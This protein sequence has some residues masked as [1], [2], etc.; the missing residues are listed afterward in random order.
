MAEVTE[1]T[2]PRVIVLAAGEGF[3]LD[4]FNK[5]LIKHPV[6]GEPII[7]HYQRLFHGYEMTVV[8]GFRALAVMHEYPALKYI[9]CADWR[10]NKNAYSLAL[11]LDERPSIVLSSDFFLSHRLVEAIKSGPPD[12]VLAMHRENRSEGALNLSVDGGLVTGVYQGSPRSALDPEAPGVFKASSPA[13]LRQWR[14]RCYEHP[15]RFCLETLPLQ[16]KQAPVQALNFDGD[17][18]SEVNS[19]QDYINLAERL[20]R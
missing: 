2:Q 6:S 19:P 15:N 18:L 8:V 12:C 13:L 1:A 7:E 10:L 3:Q 17:G 4:G 20:R 9:Y 11:A 14:R 16:E 5:L